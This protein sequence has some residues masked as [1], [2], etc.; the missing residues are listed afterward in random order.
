MKKP[1]GYI[2]LVVLLIS[3]SVSAAENDP[4]IDKIIELG[5]TDNQVMQHAHYICNVFG[6]RITGSDAYTHA[7]NWA[8]DEF[9]SWGMEAELDYVAE[10]PV[11]FNRGPWFG[12]MTK[13]YE[14]SL[15]FGTPSYTAPTR[16]VQRGHV[17]IAPNDKHQLEEIKVRIKGAWILIGSECEYLSELEQAG[18]LGVIRAAEY[19]IWLKRAKVDSWDNLP[20]LPDIRLLDTQYK[21]I[22][23]LVEDG[24]DVELEF[25]IRNHFYKGPVKYHN[26]IAWIPGSEKPEEYVIMGGHLDSYDSGT[27]A[28]DN[29][30]GL[31]PA[32][33]AARLI[34][35]SGAK[36][37]RTI[38]VHLWASEEFGIHGSDTYVENHA[39]KLPNI[40]A[41]LNSDYGTNAIVGLRVPQHMLADFE[42]VTAPIH[43]LN[44]QIPFKLETGKANG[45]PD[46]A[47]FTRKGIPAFE[48]KL[49]GKH[50]YR[51]TWHTMLD[52]YNE[53][54]PEYQEHAAIVTAITA[55]GLA[56]LDHLLER[57]VEKQSEASSHSSPGKVETITNSIGM[58]LVN[59]SPGEFMMGSE[60]SPEESAQRYDRSAR[61]FHSEHPQ[62][63]VKISRGF[64]M[65]Q[66]EVTRA[67]FARFV[68]ETQYITDAEQV[69][70][71]WAYVRHYKGIDY[72]TQNGEWPQVDGIHWKNPGF[73]QDDSHPVTC[74]S[75]FDA[76]VFCQWLSQKEGRTYRL[77]TEAEWEYACRAGSQSVYSW[78]DTEDSG[79]GWCNA[80][81]LS[82]QEAYPEWEGFK[83]NDGYTHTAPVGLFK[84]NAFGLYNMHGNVEEW[85]WDWFDGDYYANSPEADPQGPDTSSLE[86]PHRILRGG[87]WSTVPRRCR[88]A[89]RSL[90]G[91]DG[92]DT[93]FGFRVVM[94]YNE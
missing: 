61:S 93:S 56:N 65:G 34:M 77:P 85:C 63:R 26:V 12:K 67:Q 15:Y 18:A 59:I 80:L 87:S 30:S 35:K 79:D 55:Y 21:E 53:I 91:P 90:S 19:P 44:P 54:I 37:K 84:P 9:R 74:M 33:E 57:K 92:Q 72:T 70:W 83:W 24:K 17:V 58:K 73:E 32:M 7:A 36:P 78:G 38:M 48:W 86:H 11:G 49:V 28:T 25:D 75:W 2:L 27:G 69:G 1:S 47:S 22:K 45:G 6:G 40:S 66:T 29:A 23:E 14:Q 71:C 60:L 46:G 89:N 20:T 13:P 76:M 51:R 81:D 31:C 10:V 62:H 50:N 39:E 5:R 68:E 3:A 41:V 52:T 4:V 43:D 82:A 42:Q 64:Y 88:S 16:G 8:L 94:E